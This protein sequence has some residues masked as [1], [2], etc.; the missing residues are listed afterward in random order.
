[1]SGDSDVVA[2]VTLQG[3]GIRYTP[4]L[5]VIVADEE[6]LI[7]ARARDVDRFG[8][9]GGGASPVFLIEQ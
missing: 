7:K 3:L 5:H 9:W 4:N 2:G 6:L 1:L 8:V